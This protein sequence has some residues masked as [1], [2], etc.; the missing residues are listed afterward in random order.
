MLEKTS[1]YNLS[2]STLFQLRNEGVDQKSGPTISPAQICEHDS[3]RRGISSN[4]QQFVVILWQR[5]EQ[6]DISGK[7]TKSFNLIEVI[8]RFIPEI[9]LCPTL[10]YF[11][12]NNSWAKF[13]KTCDTLKY[14]LDMFLYRKLYLS[15]I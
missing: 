2:S 7:S 6:V 8:Y 10:F 14:N 9:L 3:I 12:I 1:L 11:I 13:S 5:T 4:R 15:F